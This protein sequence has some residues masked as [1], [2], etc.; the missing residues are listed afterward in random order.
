MAQEIVNGN[1][2]KECSFDFHGNHVMQRLVVNLGKMKP[3][4]PVFL[5][6]LKVI[7][8]H[9]VGYSYNEF[10]CR[11]VQ[12]MIES[13]DVGLISKSLDKIIENYEF[14]R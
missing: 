12:R 6:V 2:I 1:V 11:I 3:T 7:E 9:I 4:P 14:L 5:E 10:C 13:C 8:E